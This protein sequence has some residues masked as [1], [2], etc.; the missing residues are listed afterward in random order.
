VLA[1]CNNS[2]GK[3]QSIATDTLKVK[4]IAQNVEADAVVQQQTVQAITSLPFGPR[5]GSKKLFSNGGR[6]YLDLIGDGYS[7]DNGFKRFTPTYPLPPITKYMY[8]VVDTV[9][10]PRD[11]GYGIP[12]DSVFRVSRYRV[13]LPDHEGFEVYYMADIAGIN[14]ANKNLTPGFNGRCANFELHFYGLL[15]FYKSVTK[16]AHLLPVYYNYFGESEHERHFYIDKNY[17]ITICNK[18][19]SEGDYDSKDPVNIMD[20]PRYE[21]T[22]KKSGDFA[23]KKFEE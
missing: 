2:P 23:I 7:P 5:D 8:T 19:C 6:F 15:I 22:M 1:S 16:I 20:G 14:E 3:E 13:R 9:Y 4:H 21:V 17:R 10:D 12:L 11:C 18:I